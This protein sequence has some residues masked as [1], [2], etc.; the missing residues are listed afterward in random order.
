[1]IERLLK[2][3]IAHR[4][5][6]SKA[7]K[8][9]ENTLAAAA[10]AI[11]KGYAI[12]CDIQRSKDGEAMVFHDFRL[13]R[14]LQADGR[15]DAFTA[16]ELGAIPFREGDERIATLPQLLIEVRG[17][18]PLVVE[19][20]SRFDGDLRLADRAIELAASYGGALY[21]KS[22]DPEVL[23]HIRAAG[24]AC[25]LGLIAQAHYGDEEDWAH[26]TPERRSLL[27]T[28]CDY[29]RVAPNFLSWRVGDL[30]HAI[31]Q[32]FRAGIGLPV[33][34]WTVRSHEA[35][36]A[37]APWADQIIFEGFEA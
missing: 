2:R 1:M 18:A 37:A 19:I 12:E 28:L 32:L 9:V 21:L 36:T 24:V 13:D 16:R 6:H 23:A 25:P 34:T 8:R 22:F 26:L 17:Q 3:P 33:V 30:P 29:A 31:P 35:R 27:T 4:G 20:K 11:A 14:L 10:A 15:L 7:E 5:L